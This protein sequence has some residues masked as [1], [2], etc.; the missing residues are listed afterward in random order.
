[1]GKDREPGSRDGTRGKVAVKLAALFGAGR[2]FAVARRFLP[3][4]RPHR[5]R[6]ALVTLA[7]LGAVGM[8]LLRP[9]PIK[10]IVD[11]ALTSQRPSSHSPAYIVGWGAGIALA[12]VLI[13]AA[14]DYFAAIQIAQ[15]GR[16]VSRSLRAQL[17][18]RLTRLSPAFHARFKSGDLLVRLMGDVPLVRAMLVESS[19]AVL[20]RVVLIGATVG[21]MLWVDWILTLA[22][23]AVIPLFLVFLFL[24]SRELRVAA[25]KQRTK[26][27]DLADHLHESIAATA[28]IQ[29]LGCGDHVAER[30]A[31]NN[32]R[33]LRAE[34][35]ATRLSARLAVSVDTLF[36]VCI[37]V[38]LGVGGWR[39]LSGH[40]TAG[41]LVMFTS[42]VRSMLKPVRSTSK[43]SERFAKGTA[44]GERLL[45]ILDEPIAITSP[46]GAPAPSASP[47][48]LTFDGVQFAY[49]ETV[50]ALRGF[51]AS[52]EPGKLVGLFGRSGSGKS[53]VAA[54]AVRLY[55]PDRGEVRLDGRSLREYDLDG[56]RARFA[57]SMQET[58][59]FGDTL[60]ENLLLGAPD[61]DDEQLK[62]ALR[63][64]GAD[65]FVDRLPQGLD[66][67]LGSGGVGLSGGERR[68]ICLARTFMRPAPILIV[69]EPFTGLDRI[70]VEHVRASLAARAEHGI[71]IV[72]AHDLDHLELFDRI[73][74]LDQGRVEDVGTHLELVARSSLYRR[75][76]RGAEGSAHDRPTH[77]RA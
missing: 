74:F 33:A 69:D 20:T 53:T 18:T 65:S 40:M 63:E 44:C 70:A 47:R 25:R 51:D 1:M 59:L 62:V 75:S 15:V 19:V 26:E 61:A 76:T 71:V 37:A 22:V 66:T 52:F 43:H 54:L 28:L 46:S 21:V 31:R 12:I 67:V 32:S 35:K 39:V 23:V 49:G 41:E 24:T 3:E 14:L 9:W 2:G 68:R 45:A 55:D 36:G 72:I 6:L 17:F 4:L 10:W 60:R 8:E 56:L 42:Y 50:E 27:G 29:S 30:F 13:D 58:V 73:V 5:L 34:L 16:G 48:S 64:A 57:L 38:A 11:S 77:L 7:T